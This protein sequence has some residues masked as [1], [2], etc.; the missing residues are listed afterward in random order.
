MIKSIDCLIFS[1]ISL[2]DDVV[3]LHIFFKFNQQILKNDY[4]KTRY[5]TYMAVSI[6][7]GSFTVICLKKPTP[8]S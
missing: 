8:T 1:Q 3:L 5:I 7:I 2:R 4:F 6:Y